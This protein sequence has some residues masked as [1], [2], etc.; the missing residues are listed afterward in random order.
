MRTV[1]PIIA[2][3]RDEHVIE[4]DP[5]LRPELPGEWRRRINPFPIPIPGADSWPPSRMQPPNWAS[6]SSIWK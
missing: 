3:I 6:T 1:S 4:V 5:P 2:P